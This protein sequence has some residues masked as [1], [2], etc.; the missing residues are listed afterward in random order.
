M[1]RESEVTDK[2][3]AEKLPKATQEENREIEIDVQ[4]DPFP[5]AKPKFSKEAWD[6][7]E[8]GGE[9]GEGEG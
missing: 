8:G 7:G 9:G 4:V 1:T 5:M 6:S 3:R 2:S